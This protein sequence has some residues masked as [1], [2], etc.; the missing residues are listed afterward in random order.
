MTQRDLRKYL[1]RHNLR[2]SDLAWIAGV[3]VRH[4]RSWAIGEYAVP[5]Y[6]ELILNALEEGCITVEWIARMSDDKLPADMKY[7]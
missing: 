1:Q 5:R 2:Q 4:A 3:N 7:V 6:V